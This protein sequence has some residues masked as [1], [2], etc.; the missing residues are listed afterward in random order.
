[1]SVDANSLHQGQ[2]K[3][4]VHQVS[5]HF[6]VGNDCKPGIVSKIGVIRDSLADTHV[7]FGDKACN[8]CENTHISGI[9]RDND[10]H[11]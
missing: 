5:G 2:V 11:S 10:N 9:L 1:M 3:D 7:I 8:F 4:F 6:A